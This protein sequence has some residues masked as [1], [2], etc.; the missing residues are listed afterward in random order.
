MEEALL[1]VEPRLG[2]EALL[3]PRAACPAGL[4]VPARIHAQTLGELRLTNACTR[5]QTERTWAQVNVQYKKRRY[6]L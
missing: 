4:R 6:L 1:V 5:P 3:V 2:C